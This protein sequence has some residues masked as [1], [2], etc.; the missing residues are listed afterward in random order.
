MTISIFDQKPIIVWPV[1]CSCGH[2]FLEKYQWKKPNDKGE[3]GFCWCGFCRKKRM[4]KP[5]QGQSKRY[6]HDIPGYDMEPLGS[7]KHLPRKGY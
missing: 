7:S 1:Q 6:R 3:I 4:V 5:C 2:I